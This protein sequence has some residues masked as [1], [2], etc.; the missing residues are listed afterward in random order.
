MLA[1][2]FN[3]FKK[4]SALLEHW[5]SVLPRHVLL[6]VAKRTSQTLCLRRQWDAA[7]RV[8]D[9][10]FDPKNI[11]NAPPT[12]TSTTTSTTTS[13]NESSDSGIS[14]T[15][16]D[17][18]DSGGDNRAI[19]DTPEL[20][21]K[22][23]GRVLDSLAEHGYY[24]QAQRVIEKALAR[25][26][27]P[28]VTWLN[29]LL[30][31]NHFLTLDEQLSW[32]RR[33][34]EYGVRADIVTYN[35]MMRNY[36]LAGHAAECMRLYEHMV[37][38]AHENA[39][40][41][42]RFTLNA[43]MH[44]MCHSSSSS[45][46]SSSDDK[47]LLAKTKGV[48]VLFESKWGVTPSLSTCHLLLLAYAKAGMEPLAT[49][50]IEHMRHSKDGVRPDVRC[51]SLLAKTMC[52]PKLLSRAL[53]LLREPQAL[54][55]GA[56]EWPDATTLG[57]LAAAANKYERLDVATTLVDEYYTPNGRV[58]PD[59]SSMLSISAVAVAANAPQLALR[60]FDANHEHLVASLDS[61]PA[62]NERPGSM[63]PRQ[64]LEQAQINMIKA[65]A[66]HTA[67]THDSMRETLERFPELEPSVH[68]R[69]VQ[70]LFQQERPDAIRR[71]LWGLEQLGHV[72]L[73]DDATKLTMLE[74]L[75]NL[76]D[77][78]AVKRLAPQLAPTFIHVLELQA[79]CAASGPERALAYILETPR[80]SDTYE[81]LFERLLYLC[82]Q[83]PKQQGD[84]MV[85]AL[86]S[87]VL[88]QEMPHLGVPFTYNVYYN[89]M[90][91]L[92]NV[93]SRDAVAALARRAE[94][95]VDASRQEEWQREQRELRALACSSAGVIDEAYELLNELASSG[96]PLPTSIVNRFVE[97]HAEASDAARERAV[98]LVK[99]AGLPPQQQRRLVAKLEARQSPGSE[100]ATATAVAVAAVDTSG[101]E[102]AAL[103]TTL[104]C[105]EPYVLPA[106]QP[107]EASPAGV[108]EEQIGSLSAT[109]EFEQALTLIEHLA[110]DEI[111]SAHAHGRLATMAPGWRSALI[112]VLDG[113]ITHCDAEA[114]EKVYLMLRK[115]GLRPTRP[116]LLRMLVL[117]CRCNRLDDALHLFES[118]LPRLGL[119]L[120][121][122]TMVHILFHHLEKGDLEC[123]SV[124]Q[125]RALDQLVELV[126]AA[127]HKNPSCMSVLERLNMV[128]RP[129]R[130]ARLIA[131][132]LRLLKH[133]PAYRSYQLP[134]E[135]ALRRL[136]QVL[137]KNGRHEQL[138][139]LAKALADWQADV[140]DAASTP[141][142]NLVAYVNALSQRTPSS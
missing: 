68:S 39:C 40:T 139:R 2:A 134:S 9:I 140:G 72:A 31:R 96:E 137:V 102:Q 28:S 26:V 98:H 104:D 92:A 81:T 5:S 136:A 120:R 20:R 122:P 112:T 21:S 7:C 66:M 15:I 101:A 108:Y 16:D 45:S 89:A 141:S 54:G 116:V 41:P 12:L 3:D 78:A 77:L 88:E 128:A 11:R 87:R 43:L 6:Y 90:W 34:E 94:G 107:Q 133:E 100:Q 19:V 69:V 83:L 91:A 99:R 47:A 53:A 56:Q 82:A 62:N 61:T 131:N 23:Y 119:D 37:E 32:I 35:T 106:Q 84:G 1:S 138:S 125:L 74:A 135:P 110:M 71:L 24:Q 85:D 42:N 60:L 48:L 27:Q 8:L 109:G 55:L 95:L 142:P 80:T 25:Q 73:L 18:D 51:Y 105:R 126:P 79:H 65:V 17:H 127:L 33:F 124:D 129:E 50:L 103:I 29:V 10:V 30:R 86:V 113:C 118:V 22:L 130:A 115:L 13:T 49:W 132:S 46:S 38:N 64:Q 76:G 52:T 59:A 93:G 70:H 97:A 75:A 57:T 67:T 111:E 4:G 117:F 44:A 114:G 58:R 14:T 121:D 123:K 63:T 36:G